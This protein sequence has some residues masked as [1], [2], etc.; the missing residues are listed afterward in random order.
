MS[1][2]TAPI[3][4]V[5]VGT[6]LGDEIPTNIGVVQGDCLSAIFFIVYLAKAIK[7]INQTTE[8]DHQDRIL[9]SALDW[10]I[11]RDQHKVNIDLKYADDI[12]YIRSA[13]CNINAVKR[14]VPQQLEEA[15]LIE[16]ENKR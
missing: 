8:E 2:L 15:D 4:Q 11:P 16:N 1:C 14:A 9:W 3:V 6:D 10:V 7:P 13:R 12:T 5:R